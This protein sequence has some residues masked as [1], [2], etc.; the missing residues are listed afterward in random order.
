MLL[1]TGKRKSNVL[2][3]LINDKYIT[4]EFP[5]SFLMMHRDVT[6]ITDKKACSEI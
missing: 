5:V 3:R 4:T 1:L 6:I 2:N